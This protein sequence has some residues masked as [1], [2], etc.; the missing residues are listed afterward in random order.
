MNPAM[1]AQPKITPMYPG[2]QQSETDDGPD[3]PTAPLNTVVICAG[4][5]TSPNTSIPLSEVSSLSC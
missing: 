2:I 4:E 5:G 1:N 3:L